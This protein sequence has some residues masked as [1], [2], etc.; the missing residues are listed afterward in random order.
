MADPIYSQLKDRPYDY[1]LDRG[2]T[3]TQVPMFNPAGNLESQPVKSDGSMHDIWLDTFIASTN[4]SPKKTGFYIDGQR[5]YAEFQNVYIS[6][7]IHAMTGE[8]GGFLIGF[9]YIEDVGDSFGMASTITNG[10]PHYPHPPGDVRFWAGDT[11]MNRWMAP[12]RVYENGRVVT[13]VK[14]DPHT[15]NGAR[16]EIEENDITLFDDSVG[17]TGSI[18]GNTASLNF[19]RADGGAGI[20][21]FQ[22]RHGKDFDA[23]NVFE[24][25]VTPPPTGRHNFVFFGRKGDSLSGNIS[26]WS[27]QVELKTTEP[28]DVANGHWSVEVGIDGVAGYSPI[29]VTDNRQTPSGTGITSMVSG[30]LGGAASVVSWG[31]QGV[32]SAILG[33]Y[34][35][36]AFGKYSKITNISL[37]GGIV[38][39]TT[40]N[41]FSPGEKVY[42]QG[43]THSTYLQNQLLP[44]TLLTATPTQLTFAF[45]HPNDPSH[46]DTGTVQGSMNIGIYMDHYLYASLGATLIPDT[47]VSYDLGDT[48]HHLNDIYISGYIQCG[49][50]NDTYFYLSDT[51][52]LSQIGFVDSGGGGFS[53][54]N[55]VP[56]VSSLT[57]YSSDAAAGGAGLV[58]G[59]L[60]QTSGGGIG[61]FAFLGVV[62]VKQ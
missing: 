38:T 30:F 55:G 2:A 43:V 10:D 49:P 47:D 18:T 37:S 26:S 36:I 61:V 1:Y 34:S 6:G 41:N 14:S 57:H 27:N 31:D 5:G 59:D 54:K 15:I 60:Y 39:I 35:G 22:K 32:G 48:T 28:F 3:N 56:A 50:T 52:P 16:V 58:A 7:D 17:G 46:A 8:I 9:D 53:S 42:L 45:V 40:L 25:F 44:F 33:N 21:T 11:F 51:G 62:M 20:Y 29:I 23:D 4:W 24:I 19:E 13:S 12:F